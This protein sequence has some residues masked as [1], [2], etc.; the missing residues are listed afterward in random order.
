MSSIYTDYLGTTTSLS[1]IPM[2]LTSGVDSPPW[3]SLVDTSP[4]F[5]HTAT[6]GQ[7]LRQTFFLDGQYFNGPGGNWV[8]DVPVTSYVTVVPEPSTFVMGG[9]ALVALTVFGLRRRSGRLPSHG[10]SGA[11]STDAGSPPEIC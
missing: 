2:N 8:I 4:V 1:L 10:A 9:S 5:S 7:F 3:I 6:A 11:A